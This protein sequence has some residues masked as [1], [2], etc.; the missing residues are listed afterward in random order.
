MTSTKE[1]PPTSYSIEHADKS[2]EMLLALSEVKSDKLSRQ[3]YV[4]HI[5]IGIEAALAK[6]H[7]LKDIAQKLNE[8]GFEIAPGTL[9][10]YLPRSTKPAAVKKS[11]KARTV[12]VASAPVTPSA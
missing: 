10:S 4:A 8:C 6:G 5:R 12:H 7:T 1:S 9:K 2:M 11:T 3:E